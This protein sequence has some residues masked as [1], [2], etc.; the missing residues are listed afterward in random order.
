MQSFCAVCSCARP[1]ALAVLNEFVPKGREPQT[2]S[3]K[4]FPSVFHSVGGGQDKIV[5]DK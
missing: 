5:G 4:T 3:L 1:Y 2:K